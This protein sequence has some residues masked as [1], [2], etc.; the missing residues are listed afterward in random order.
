MEL[1]ENK[2]DKCK[3]R[4]EMSKEHCDKCKNY[5]GNKPLFQK[6]DEPDNF[7]TKE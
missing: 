7:E 1:K 4:M 6:N 2:C 5:P 3:W